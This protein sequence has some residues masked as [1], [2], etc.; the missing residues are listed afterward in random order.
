MIRMKFRK[1]MG[2]IL[3]LPAA[4]RDWKGIAHGGATITLPDAKLGTAEAFD[5]LKAVLGVISAIYKTYEV[6]P[7]PPLK[8]F[9]NISNCRKQLP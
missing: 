7:R 1:P 6:R 2:L 9:S 3:F 5:S 8:P 4:N